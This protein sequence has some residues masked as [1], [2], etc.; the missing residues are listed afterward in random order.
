MKKRMISAALALAMVVPQ[1]ATMVQAEEVPTLT[2]FVDETWWPYDTWEGAIPEE[3]ARRVGVNIE[4]TRAAD[5]NQ[6][7][8]MVSSG[9]MPDLIC[10]YR[11]QYLADENVCYALD[12]LRL[13]QQG[14]RWPLL[15]D[16]LWLF[17]AV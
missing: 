3:F 15:H 4:V 6:L 17:P 14:G 10:S 11:Y 7:A 8:L 1:A 2:L 12:E 9:D 16:W 5:G 13:C